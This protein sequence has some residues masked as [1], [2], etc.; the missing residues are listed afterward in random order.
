MTGAAAVL[1]V[2]SEIDGVKRHE[3]KRC[4]FRRLSGG[5]E[6]RYAETDGETAIR[7]SRRGLGEGNRAEIESSGEYSGLMVIEPGRASPC[8]MHT[9][10]G[11]LN[12][13]VRGSFV[14]FSLTESGAE[15]ELSYETSLAGSTAASSIEYS[16][17][18]RYE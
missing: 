15:A 14:G 10:Q 4:I 2:F 8:C 17:I 1:T 16:F 3:D 11:R 5:F 13:R 12:L 18:V 6:V 9:P 7:F